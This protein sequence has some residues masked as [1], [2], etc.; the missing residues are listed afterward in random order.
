MLIKKKAY[1][2]FYLFLLIRDYRNIPNSDF[3]TPN[4]YGIMVFMNC[5]TATKYPSSKFTGSVE[6]TSQGK[7]ILVVQG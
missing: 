7:K 5:Y 6:I 1:G 2:H 3:K 4:L